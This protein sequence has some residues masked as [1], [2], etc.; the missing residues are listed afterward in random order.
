MGQFKKW[1]PN[2]Q[3]VL[4]N[5]VQF[6]YFF[7]TCEYIHQFWWKK[8]PSLVKTYLHHFGC[9]KSRI[10]CH[11]QS[12]ILA[13][14]DCFL[15][16][17]MKCDE[18]GYHS[19]NRWLTDIAGI[20]QGLSL[21]SNFWASRSR[22][23]LPSA[24]IKASVG[25]YGLFASGEGRFERLHLSSCIYTSY[26]RH[27]RT[28]HIFMPSHQKPN[29]V[30]VYIFSWNP[31]CMFMCCITMNQHDS[32]DPPFFS[33]AKSVHITSFRIGMDWIMNYWSLLGRNERNL[34]TWERQSGNRTRLF[35]N[36][37]IQTLYVQ[38]VKF[39]IY[40]GWP[41]LTTKW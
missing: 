31:K 11:S 10:P 37:K 1:Q 13:S 24:L 34:R 14:K 19:I 7:I 23:A 26:T 30:I 40:A 41:D 39:R 32:V 21:L 28:C 4:V 6:W 22:M 35:M 25:F 29:H 3:P 9:R 38:S 12:K 15:Y 20:T 18:L 27:F 16:I 33:T 36:F 8:Y 2:H 17:Y 5:Q